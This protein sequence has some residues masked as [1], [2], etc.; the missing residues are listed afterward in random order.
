MFTI[1]II[2]F[3]CPLLFD[4]YNFAQI[5]VTVDT[6]C[7]LPPS[8]LFLSL[9]LLISSFPLSFHLPLSLL[10]YYGVFH[11]L[12]TSLSLTFSF[13]SVS[14]FTSISLFYLPLSPSLFLFLLPSFYLFFIKSLFF[15]PLFLPHFLLLS[16]SL[17]LSHFLPK[18]LSHSFSVSQFLLPS[19]PSFHSLFS[20]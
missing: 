11:C 12:F 16:I 14:P 20:L 18:Y 10:H 2:L 9:S 19:F 4:K 3:F 1:Y 17:L 13:T 7:L 6:G 15:P 5:Y 8:T